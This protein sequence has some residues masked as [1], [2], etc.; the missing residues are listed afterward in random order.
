V[1][2]KRLPPRETVAM[3]AMALTVQMGAIGHAGAPGQ[4]GERGMSG[5]DGKDGLPG[6]GGPKATPVRKGL[7]ATSARCLGTSGK[8]APSFG[9]A[10][11]FGKNSFTICA[12]HAA[13]QAHP[14]RMAVDLARPLQTAIH[15]LNRAMPIESAVGDDGL[16]SSRGQHLLNISSDRQSTPGSISLESTT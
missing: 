2:P 12:D 3:A 9:G 10:R 14:A 13:I 6:P 4:R 16:P 5:T 15:P 1:K 11:A 8:T 7:M